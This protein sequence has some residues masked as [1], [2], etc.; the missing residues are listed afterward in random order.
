MYRE[1][2]LA[3]YLDRSPVAREQRDAVH[4]V[5]GVPHRVPRVLHRMVGVLH[6]VVGV[7]HRVVGVLHRVLGKSRPRPVHQARG[8]QACHP[9]GPPQKRGPG[10]AIRLG[11]APTAAPV[12]TL[13]G[14]RCALACA[15]RQPSPIPSPYPLRSPL[16][17]L[18][19]PLSL[20]SPIPSPFPVRSP[21]PTL[22][23]PLRG[24]GFTHSPHE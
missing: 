21:L 8:S 15:G 2:I 6:R 24:G 11:T 20:P 4:G 22:S 5:V 18:S 19:D 16:P 9:R 1:T 23:D 10:T 3:A 12:A 13:T 7:P 14:G 17:T